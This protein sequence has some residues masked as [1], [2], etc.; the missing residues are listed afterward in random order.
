MLTGPQSLGTAI[1]TTTAYVAPADALGPFTLAMDSTLRLTCAV[2]SAVI[3]YVRTGS[4]AANAIN[5]SM[6]LGV[7]LTVNAQ[8]SWEM[9]F[10]KGTVISIRFSGNCNINNLNLQQ[11]TGR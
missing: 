6:E 10:P 5:N 1:Q 7:P 2:D 3:C 4:T 9:G 11:F 8:H